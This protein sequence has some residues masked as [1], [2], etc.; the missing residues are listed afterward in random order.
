VQTSGD[1]IIVAVGVRT[2]IPPKLSDSG[3]NLY[4]TSTQ[5]AWD[6]GAY[7]YIYYASNVR[8]GTNF[9]VTS[10]FGATTYPFMAAFEYSGIAKSS[11]LDTATSTE[12][13]DPWNPSNFTSGTSITHT[14][15]DLIIGYAG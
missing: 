7:N 11:P 2:S 8:G 4:V 5:L 9:T 13:R 10:T 15:G 12:F 6:Y 1:T 3:G 14:A